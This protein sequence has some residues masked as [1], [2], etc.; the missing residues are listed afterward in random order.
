MIQKQ[1]ELY[2]AP[3]TNVLELRFE[4]LVCTSADPVS[5]NDWENGDDF[6][7]GF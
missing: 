3:I 4:G 7:L 2:E 5:I 6:P 1:L